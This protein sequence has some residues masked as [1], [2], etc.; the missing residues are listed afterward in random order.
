LQTVTDKTN[1]NYGE[2]FWGCRNWRNR[3]EKGCNHFKWLDDEDD[4][5]DERDMKIAKQNK[6]IGKLKQS[7]C[8]L[9]EELINSRKCC[10]I[11]LEF[12]IVCFRFNML[13]MSVLLSI[14]VK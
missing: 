4:V 12:G 13:L 6:K 1:P 11:V 8:F 3:I 10:K 7:I 2:K 14:Y 5:V 9:K